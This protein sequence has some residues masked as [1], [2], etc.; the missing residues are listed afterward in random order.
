MESKV[1]FTSRDGLT[2]VANRR[3]DPADP[4]VV[5]LHGGGQ[6]RHSWGGTAAAVAAAGWCAWTVDSRG[7]G[8][9]DWSPSGDYRLGSFAADVGVIVEE[10][11]GRPALIGA[12]LGGLTSLLLLGRDSP[13]VASGLVLVDVVPNMEKK[14]TDRI[15]AFMS[16]NAKTGF[17]SLEEAAESVA[18]YNHHRERPP[19]LD[20]L[21]KNLRERDGRWYWH[22]DPDFIS[23][24]PDRGPSEINDPDLLMGC[25]KAIAEPMMLVRG[26]MSD[27]VSPEGAEAFAADVPNATFVDVSEAGH[28]VAGDRNDAFTGAVTGFLDSLN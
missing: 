4:D 25:A 8:E 2:L 24:R 21:R 15:A 9:S 1:T 20:G 17:A 12:S 11:G 28:M 18:A 3:G 23:P 6:T 14:G 7:H 13:G 26:R 22:W 16:E 27:V 5:F 19:S 10:I